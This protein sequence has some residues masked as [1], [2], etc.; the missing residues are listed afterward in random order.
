MHSELQP[1]RDGGPR[2]AVSTHAS[3]RCRRFLKNTTAIVGSLGLTF[4]SSA[5][6]LPAGGVVSAGSASFVGAPDALT[7]NQSSPNVA[8]NWQSFSIGGHESVTF[9][10]PNRSS[11]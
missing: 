9:L 8:I 1:T 7:I 11:V 5:W 2:G 10:Q 4:G 6:A 3:S